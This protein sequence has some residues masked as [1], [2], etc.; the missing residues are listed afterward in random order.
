MPYAGYGMNAGIADAMDLSW[1]L[2]A[3]LKGWAPE[4]LLDAYERERQP[5]TEQVSKFA[6]EMALNNMRQRKSTPPEVESEGPEGDAARARVGKEAYELNVH[7]YCCGGLNFGYFYSQSPVIAYDGGEHPKYTMYDFT[8]STVPG[9]RAPH[10]FLADGSSLYDALGP[11][12]SLLRFD[13]AV[14]VGGLVQAAASR[15]VPL[16][17]VDVPMEA[18]RDLYPHKLALV[19]PD[20]HIAWR[21]DTEP[22]DPMALIDLIR[23][24]AVT[25]ARK[26]A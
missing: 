25:A 13:P 7:Q 1:M 4:S 17:V 16:K 9:C 14:N 26:A 3:V 21:G 22:S 2:A 10:V 15:G 24:A 20:Q 5:I 12:Y 23:G 11:D 18:V 8:P 6:M 19:R